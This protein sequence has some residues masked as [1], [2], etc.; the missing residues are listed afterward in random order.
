MTD[1][2]SNNLTTEQT[3]PTQAP[4]NHTDQKNI[5][6]VGTVSIGS[7]SAMALAAC[8]DGGETAQSPNPGPAPV[9]APVPP[10]D[11][12][13]S[14]LLGQAA[15]GATD[16]SIAQ[17]HRL[18][19]AD[20]LEQQ[21][22]MT[23]NGTR[24]SWLTRKGFMN[25]AFRMG[26][27]GA[28]QCLWYKAI[29]S[30]DVV[31]QRMALALS[32]IFVINQRSLNGAGGYR[33]FACGHYM[34]MLESHAFGNYRELLEDVTLS[35]QMGCYLSMRGSQKAN[36][37]GRA[38]DEN[39]A[40]EVLQLFSIGL[41]EL[42]ADGTQ[43][44]DSSGN[45]IETYVQEDVIGLARAFT[46]WD[47]DGY[48]ATSA[49]HWRRPMK[50]FP[51][52]HEPGEKRF[53]GITIAPDTD[54]QECMQRALDTIANHPNVAPFF[55]KQLIQRFITSNPSPAFVGRVSAVFDNDGEG[56]RGNL[57]A[58]VRAILLDPE[59]RNDEN[60]LSN[61][62]GKVR[63]PM[64]RFIQW[65]RTFN[66]K[67]PTDQWNIRDMSN[68]ALYLGQSPLRAISVFNFFRPGFTPS[69]TQLGDVGMVAPELQITS[70]TTVAGY[71]NLMQSVIRN[72]FAG[73]EA[74]YATELSLVDSPTA[75]VLRI[76]TLLTANQLTQGTFDTI[77][78]VVESMRN[79]T[80]TDKLHR[81]YAAILLVMT[82]PD[83]V[84]QK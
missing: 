36:A 55:S 21:F 60:V 13:V 56:V 47:T 27:N 80:P 81:V 3:Q 1:P 49:E 8:G 66:A 18:G 65:A 33:N 7:L 82:A 5:A 29:T 43:K 53:L 40:R 16:D 54:G 11:Q 24:W 70:E 31:R 59:A 69:N 67:D 48:V 4:G 17:V 37:T 14:R 41:Y 35:V 63:E 57:R 42:N 79:E 72:G 45:P 50:F 58:V 23:G 76:D 38:P 61:S 77:L 68:G 28:D 30:P 73:V 20:W 9:P 25:D 15:F 71:A 39:Y 12:Q 64:I 74:D 44:L 6:R 51:Q 83:Y 62:F 32:E 84:V 19:M 22:V 52:H 34:D 75:L 10:T 46:G 78:A 2:V 26:I